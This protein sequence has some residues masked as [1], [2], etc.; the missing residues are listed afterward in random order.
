M[1]RCDGEHG[2]DVAANKDG[3]TAA[4]TTRKKN[5]RGVAPHERVEKGC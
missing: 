2:E 4:C 5:G 3:L 1:K